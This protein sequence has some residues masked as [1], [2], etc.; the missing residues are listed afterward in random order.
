ME[1]M[2]AA[3]KAVSHFK[4]AQQENS[5]SRLWSVPFIGLVLFIAFYYLSPGDYFPIL[6]GAGLNKIVAG[7]ALVSVIWS[8]LSQGRPWMEFRIEANLL[9]LFVAV[10]VVG[11]PFSAWPGGS[12]GVFTES[13]IKTLL[14][15]LLMTNVITS[16][17][18]LRTLVRV[19]VI[20]ATIIAFVAVSHYVTGMFDQWGRL[21]GY[22]E[23]EYYNPND[24]ALG[25]LT[26]IPLTFLLLL[27]AKSI[28]LRCAYTGAIALMSLAILA[29]MS[30]TGMVGLA[31]LGTA[32]LL[33]MAR[34]T[35]KKAIIGMVV[36]MAL[37][38]TSVAMVP[39]LADRFG[40][41]FDEE[42][43]DLGSRAARLEHMWDG[44]AIMAENPILGVGM[45]Q[46][47]GAV[48]A[49]HGSSG[50]HW[51][52]IHN[53]YLQVGAEGGIIALALFLAMMISETARLK[54]AERALMQG[55]DA[56][57]VKWPRC[58]RASIL[59]FIVCAN[60]SPVAYNWFFYIL[61]GLSGAALKLLAPSNVVEASTVGPS[62]SP[63]RLRRLMFQSGGAFS[64]RPSRR[65][66]RS[67]AAPLLAR[68]PSGLRARTSR[69]GVQ[70]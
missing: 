30:R 33:S 43:D 32:W 23:K 65:A 10:L 2:M 41:I 11:I 5:P 19:I 8:N 45:G 4:S 38:A 25:L 22:G 68:S 15:V 6:E 28:F 47:P 54:R 34:K 13:V 61:L 31:F 58:M 64:I 9:L 40:S 18:Q 24:L 1:N 16:R 63:A 12:W 50:P 59:T 48:Y 67:P 60:F 70:E 14:F 49:R 69:D 27:E 66:E 26:I 17:S 39:A 20:C 62:L 36:V 44:L 37:V 57:M 35:P 51:E 56:E 42:K 7:L 53:V 21:I 3:T 46:T 29:S 52:Q 55:P